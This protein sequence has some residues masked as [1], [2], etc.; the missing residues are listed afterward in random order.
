MPKRPV[1]PNFDQDEALWR[2]IDASGVRGSDNQVKPSSLRLQIS[3]VR[4]RYG[5]LED[6][7][8]GKFNGVA[9]ATAGAVASVAH[10][11]VR[12]VCVDEPREDAPGH[13]LIALVVEPGKNAPQDALNAARQGVAL[14]MKM[15]IDPK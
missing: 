8:L 3:V 11:D 2:R 4:A 13:A 1:D 6:A 7:P 14:K 9:E 5:K 10:G 15:V 12:I